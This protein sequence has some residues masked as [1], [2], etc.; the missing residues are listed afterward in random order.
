MEIILAILLLIEVFITI[1]VALT[2]AYEENPFYLVVTVWE[3]TEKDLNIV[4]RVIATA[5]VGI[6]TLPAML[7]SC[8]AY[9]TLIV[10]SCICELFMFVFKKRS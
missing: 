6:I 9:L 7:L 2:S 10:F 5:L 1:A 3:N 8:S 4:G